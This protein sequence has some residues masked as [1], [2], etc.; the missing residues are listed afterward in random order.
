MWYTWSFLCHNVLSMAYNTHTQTLIQYEIGF[1][2]L[3][4]YTR[5][6]KLGEVSQNQC[7]CVSTVLHHMQKRLVLNLYSLLT[8]F[9]N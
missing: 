7:N 9:L 4:T 5:L 8:I 2:K 6:E 1:G 3:Q